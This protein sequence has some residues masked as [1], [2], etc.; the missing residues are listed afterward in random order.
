MGF[1]AQS[2]EK[3][4]E[5]G[6]NVAEKER[7]KKANARPVFTWATVGTARNGTLELTMKGRIKVRQNGKTTV[8]DVDDVTSVEIEDGADLVR[9]TSLMRAGGAATAGGILLGPIGLLGG[10]GVGAIAKK[11]RGGEKYLTLE[12]GQYTVII[13]IPAK[14]V[15]TAHRIRRDI[16]QYIKRA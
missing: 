6:E 9:H 4:Q 13:E 1:W 2:F 5:L 16:L 10:L 11:Q 7:E 3:L 8:L 12:A 15:T 14:E